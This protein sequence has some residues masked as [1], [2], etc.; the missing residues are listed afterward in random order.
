MFNHRQYICLTV[1]LLSVLSNSCQVYHNTTARFN[2]YFLAKEKMK[3]SEEQLFSNTQ[4]DFND[5]LPVLIHLDTN[6]SR[7]QKPSF[8]YVIEKASLPIELHPTSKWI[9]NAWLV[10]GKARLYQ[11]DYMNAIHTFKYVNTI[12]TENNARHEAIVL[13]LRCFWETEQYKNME[14]TKEYIRK[15]INVPFNN[16]N[17]REYH[18]IFSAYHQEKAN[19]ALAVQHLELAIPL[20]R[21]RNEKAR[22]FYIMGQMYSLMADPQKAY[23]AYRKALRYAPTYELEFNARLKSFGLSYLNSQKDIA[24]T[25]RYYKRLLREEKNWDYRDRIYYEYALFSLRIKER[26]KAKSLLNFSIQENI[27]NPIQKAYAYLK[28]GQLYYREKDFDRAAS[29]YDSTIN[30]MPKSFKNYDE[31]K[32]KAEILNEF[33]LVYKKVEYADRLLFL[34]TLNTEELDFYF[35]KEIE[36]EKEQIIKQ[37]ERQALAAYKK[38][39]AAVREEQNTANTSFDNKK[40]NWYFYDNNALIAGRSEFLRIWGGRK[41]EDNWRRSNKPIAAFEQDQDKTQEEVVV[42]QDEAQDSDIFSSIKSKQARLEEVPSSP[43]ELQEVKDSLAA[44]LFALAK[45]YYYKLNE[46]S[47]SI[48]TFERLVIEFP[49]AADVT[50]ALYVLYNICESYDSCQSDRYEN[51]LVD[52]YPESFYAKILINPNYVEELNIIDSKVARSYEEAFQLYKIRHYGGAKKILDQILSAYPKNSLLD[53]ITLLNIMIAGQ[54]TQ[55]KMVYKAA[56]DNFITEFEESD[57]VPFAENLL[58]AFGSNK[59]STKQKD[60]PVVGEKLQDS[61]KN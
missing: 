17:T 20:V 21:K 59:P 26:E 25:K 44:S 7:S 42:T 40:G 32:Q 47:G 29:Y 33:A 55:D 54:L 2:S 10:V 53:K 18:L 41:L 43:E 60:I 22:F 61:K 12:S 11:G 52:K 23:Q 34:A 37:R 49:Q 38:N 46:Y 15:K 28:L 36:Q 13:L 35:D 5:L 31:V 45:A 51:I 27:N 9:D 1:V 4:D 16:Q 57:L 19:Y 30:I 3:E 8:D 48:T 58:S 24:K 14:L 56:L 6:A 50:E 39:K